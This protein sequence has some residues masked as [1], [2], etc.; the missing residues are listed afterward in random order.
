[1]NFR[2]IICL[3]FF[4]CVCNFG[5]SQITEIGDKELIFDVN[6]Q[7]LRM[8]YFGNKD[9]GLVPIYVSSDWGSNPAGPFQALQDS[10]N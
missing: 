3:S 4:L 7:S 10:S 6:G 1:M 9:K 2:N 5:F 8:T